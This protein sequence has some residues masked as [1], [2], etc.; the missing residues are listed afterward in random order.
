MAF[1]DDVKK[2]LRVTVTDFN[3]EIGDL[4]S[5]AKADLSLSGV[6]VDKVLDSDPLIRRAVITYCKAN[7]GYDNPDADRLTAAYYKLKQHLTLSEDYL[8]VVDDEA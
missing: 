1:L 2:A 8:G 3:G 5:A 6:D 4:I 7:F